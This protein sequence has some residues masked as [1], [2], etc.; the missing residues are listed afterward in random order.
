MD[1]FLSL[2]STGWVQ[3]YGFAKALATNPGTITFAGQVVSAGRSDIVAY[4]QQEKAGYRLWELLCYMGRHTVP[5]TLAYFD[6]PADTV[7]FLRWV[8]NH[9]AHEERERV[10]EMQKGFFGAGFDQMNFFP[11]AQLYDIWSRESDADRAA[12][13]GNVLVYLDRITEDDGRELLRYQA[14]VFFE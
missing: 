1:N 14:P 3:D 6:L 10:V 11:Y 4:W 13:E 7:P 5:Q 2:T 12:R 9:V 8:Y